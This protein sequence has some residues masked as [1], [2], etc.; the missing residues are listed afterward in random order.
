MTEF[1]EL[2]QQAEYC[3]DERSISTLQKYTEPHSVLFVETNSLGREIEES[4]LL[5]LSGG[6]EIK[7]LQI[8]NDLEEI[9]CELT[10][11]D[12]IIHH[13]L[14]SEIIMSYMMYQFGL[15]KLVR[16]YDCSGVLDTKKV[17]SLQSSFLRSLKEYQKITGIIPDINFNQFNQNIYQRRKK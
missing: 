17:S 10:D 12:D 7:K 13:L 1:A 5:Y 9:R 16:H 2:V 11:N 3:R 14:A 8:Q 15:T 6:D 4:I